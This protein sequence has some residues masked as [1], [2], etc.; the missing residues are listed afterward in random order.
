[1][2][3]R[4]SMSNISR[5]N[6]IASQGIRNVR[7]VLDDLIASGKKDSLSIEPWQYV[8]DF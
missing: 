6:Q 2:I 3:K 4:K 5:M 8:E 1:M 7:S